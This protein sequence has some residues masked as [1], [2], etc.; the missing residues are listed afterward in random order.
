MATTMQQ[1]QQ[2]IVDS[3]L[4]SDDDDAPEDRVVTASVAVP[5]DHDIVP[6]SS[7][8][9]S[10]GPALDMDLDSVDED[11]RGGGLNSHATLDQNTYAHATASS[12]TRQAF[13]T[14]H[15][16]YQQ[17]PV[18][19]NPRELT[20]NTAA[21][22]RAKTPESRDSDAPSSAL[23]DTSIATT[24]V[25][26]S[27]H[28]ELSSVETI[29]PADRPPHML[30]RSLLQPKVAGSAAEAVKSRQ[31]PRAK[32]LV[33]ASKEQRAAV[34]GES[35]PRR[36]STTT[37]S[38]SR[39]TVPRQSEDEDDELRLKSSKSHKAEDKA[40][41]TSEKPKYKSSKA[42]AQSVISSDSEEDVLPVK[43]LTSATKTSKKAGS[44][45]SKKG[46]QRAGRDDTDSSQDD[47]DDDDD[48]D[49]DLIQEIMKANAKESEDDDDYN[50]GKAASKD[51]W[52]KKG[53]KKPARRSSKAPS[54]E[55]AA[56]VSARP[57]RTKGR[58]SAV[59]PSAK[60]SRLS[61]ADTNDE[62]SDEPVPV[63]ARRKSSSR[64]NKRSASKGPEPRSKEFLDDEDMEDDVSAPTTSKITMSNA[65]KDSINGTTNDVV[66]D[67]EPAPPQPS[68][69]GPVA[70]SKPTKTHGKKRSKPAARVEESEDE[71]DGQVGKPSGSTS[72]DSNNGE[73]AH[74]TTVELQEERNSS[75]EVPSSRA[76][77]ATSP[78]YA[79][80]IDN[81]AKKGK[82][83]TSKSSRSESAQSK[84]SD[85]SI[86]AQIDDDD[87]SLVNAS[88]PA[89]KK[90]SSKKSANRI[91]DSEEEEDAGD[92]SSDT[93]EK[94]TVS[95]KKGSSNDLRSTME[96]GK[97]SS[98]M[99]VDSPTKRDASKTVLQSKDTNATASKVAESKK[100]ITVLAST[101]V[102]S[103]TTSAD[104]KPL[105]GKINKP[106]HNMV[107][108]KGGGQGIRPQGLSRR[109]KV[110]SLLSFRGIPPPKKPPLPP[111]PV[112][113][114]K[115]GEE[116]YSDEDQ[117]E[118]ND[119]PEEWWDRD[120]F[121]EWEK[122]KRKRAKARGEIDSEDEKELAQQQKKVKKEDTAVL[123]EATAVAEMEHYSD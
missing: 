6:D 103:T 111:A 24:E 5:H 61:I 101:S 98:A 26:P 40:H 31:R 106:F 78:A 62:E 1:Q 10:T 47:D 45:S 100:E 116:V 4:F 64:A 85:H 114:K 38:T 14:S 8:E 122:R 83:P 104:I 117:E 41:G 59:F 39:I 49:D 115:K 108:A 29:S 22:L 57:A 109:G 90:S 21:L 102:Q 20:V 42:A 68:S 53:K 25:I 54:E 71:D 89:K 60:K 11:G 110:P 13:K 99:K 74:A 65:A 56:K 37:S 87:R 35:P 91:A 112:K 93:E 52:S 73:K 27:Q 44:S 121:Y 84:A 80:V 69:D 50:G 58:P 82:K 3:F 18:T 76:K 16:D 36:S 12:G 32:P 19:V 120:D 66:S 55:I 43:A 123:T 63:A 28:D 92:E 30:G 23:L 79:V 118:L 81:S 105:F 94:A 33:L 51:K 67:S 96:T 77:R 75:R 46:K 2:V 17:Q 15:L 119:Q 88:S 107:V 95:E 48:A 113:K 70:R 34:R 9:A 97:C 86:P 7:D 72:K